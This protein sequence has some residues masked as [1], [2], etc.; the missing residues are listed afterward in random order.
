MM[1]D[2]HGITIAEQRAEVQ[3]LLPHAGLHKHLCSFAP[4]RPDA[5]A[6]N[7]NDTKHDDTADET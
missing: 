7:Q 3:R 5:E 4:Y 2:S 1:K 6:Y